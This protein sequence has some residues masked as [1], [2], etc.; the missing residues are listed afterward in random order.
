MLI[1]DPQ[2]Y[3]PWNNK[4]VLID[5]NSNLQTGNWDTGTEFKNANP[6]MDIMVRDHQV[7]KGLAF[8]LL[9]LPLNILMQII[10][11][12]FLILSWAQ[13]RPL[14]LEGILE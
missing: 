1:N 3:D 7:Y 6:G 8:F 10:I 14:L 5:D 2:A 12:V 9:K 4:K 13:R 11:T